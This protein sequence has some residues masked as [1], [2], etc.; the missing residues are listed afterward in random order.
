[1]S[2]LCARNL[3]TWVEIIYDPILFWFV[4]KSVVWNTHE[5]LLTKNPD[6]IE[7][8]NVGYISVTLAL[9]SL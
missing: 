7:S 1:M 5:Q 9:K 8:V 4:D 3:V 2:Y 6:V